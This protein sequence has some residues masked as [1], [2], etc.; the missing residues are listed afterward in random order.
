MS[1]FFFCSRTSITRI[2]I[3]I[4]DSDFKNCRT[5][6]ILRTLYCMCCSCKNRYIYKCYTHEHYESNVTVRESRIINQPPSVRIS[7]PEFL[8]GFTVFHSFLI[9]V[10]LKM[11]AAAVNNDTSGTPNVFIIIPSLFFLDI[12]RV[13][14]FSGSDRIPTQYSRENKCNIA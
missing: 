6:S 13:S 11:G 2:T 14:V 9:F 3:K 7:R 8:A 4:W 12:F 1:E 10:E 5:F